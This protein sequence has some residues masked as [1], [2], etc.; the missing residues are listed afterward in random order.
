MDS[1]YSQSWVRIRSDPVSTSK[2]PLA[3]SWIDRFGQRHSN[4]PQRAGLILTYRRHIMCR[5]SSAFWKS[6]TKKRVKRDYASFS[7]TFTF[8]SLLPSF[9]FYVFLPSA[10][11]DRDNATPLSTTNSQR[12]IRCLHHLERVCFYS[13]FSADIISNTHK[14]RRR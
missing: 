3:F 10:S 1:P 13:T 14:P 8:L 7:F 11:D 4:M 9:P 12:L 5:R 2:A 6:M